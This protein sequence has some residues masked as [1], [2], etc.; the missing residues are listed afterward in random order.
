[1]SF[2]A[3]FLKKYIKSQYF[4]HSYISRAKESVFNFLPFKNQDTMATEI[5]V[6]FFFVNI[7]GAPKINENT[8][9]SFPLS[10]H[11]S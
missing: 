9:C 2:K 10:P 6:R 7:F 11:P 4:C 5:K 8:V 1:M 3:V